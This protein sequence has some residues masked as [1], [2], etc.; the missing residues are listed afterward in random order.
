MSWAVQEKIK[1]TPSIVIPSL[2]QTNTR[3]DEVTPICF[4]IPHIDIFVST[5]TPGKKNN[6]QA[7]R[8]DN[9]KSW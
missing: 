2:P 3:L 9:F 6:S 4:K 5:Y 7:F 8:E 1:Q